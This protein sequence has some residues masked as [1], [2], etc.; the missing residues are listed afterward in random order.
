MRISANLPAVPDLQKGRVGQADAR[1]A[2]RDMARSLIGPDHQIRTGYLR[3]TRSG[4]MNAGG[5]LTS[6]R[7]G[8][9][10]QKIKLLIEIA[11]GPGLSQA[12]RNRLMASIDAYLGRSGG[13]VGTRT[14]VKLIAALDQRVPLNDGQDPVY[15]NPDNVRSRLILPTALPVD[16]TA[17]VINRAVLPPNPTD[18]QIFAVVAGLRDDLKSP[19]SDSAL[20]QFQALA[21][22]MKENWPAF[23][24]FARLMFPTVSAPEGVETVQGVA[25]PPTFVMGD[26]DGSMGR[27]V[28]HALASGVARLPKDKMLSLAFVIAT[29]FSVLETGQIIE[30]QGQIP[31]REELDRLADSI[32]VTPNAQASRPACI[33]LGDILSDRFTNNQSAMSRLIHTLSGVA[34]ADP[35]VRVETGVVF[36]AGN[37]DTQPLL[38]K[39]GVDVFKDIDDEGIKA[40]WGGYASNKLTLSG[41]QAVLGN[42]FRAAH[43]SDG[44]LVTHNGVAKGARSKQFLVALGDAHARGDATNAQG[45]SCADARVISARSPRDLADKMNR[46]FRELIALGRFDNAISTNF[47]PRDEHMTPTA[48]GFKVPGFRQLHGHNDDANEDHPGVTNLNARGEEGLHGFM[49][50]A[51]VIS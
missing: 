6:G 18:E 14:F 7:T 35:N 10:S 12:N 46:A 48:L 47:R 9:A 43:Y 1:V 2:L 51:R 29:E 33:F 44:V 26:A 24:H 30:F 13:A 50:V 17:A 37:H 23:L 4:T 20:E 49:P 39:D 22:Q 28:L 15:P 36:I 16:D 31:L 38:T 34:H 21:C 32:V 45:E 40:T 19:I 42:C 8:L 5:F 11:Y 27:V 25:R 41:Y 3:Q